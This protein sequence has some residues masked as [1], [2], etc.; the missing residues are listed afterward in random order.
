MSTLTYVAIWHVRLPPHYYTRERCTCYAD[1]Q[2]YKN[3]GIKCS[4]TEN[5]R[6]ILGHH[7]ELLFENLLLHH[8]LEDEG[9][10]PA[11]ES[12]AR[13]REMT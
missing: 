5:V 11:R 6:I 7:Y 10:L 12:Q 3:D 1:K 2:S 4:L 8:Q 13:V 9:E